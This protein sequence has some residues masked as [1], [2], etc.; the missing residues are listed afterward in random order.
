MRALPE[1]QQNSSDPVQTQTKLQ[2]KKK[3]VPC[4]IR[5][6]PWESNMRGLKRV[7][8]KFSHFRSL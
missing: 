1:L 2:K 4:Q 5:L 3:L 8:S 7:R 6:N